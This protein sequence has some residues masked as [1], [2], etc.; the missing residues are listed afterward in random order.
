MTWIWNIQPFSWL[1]VCVRVCACVCVC[2]I[3]NLG[4]SLVAQTVKSLPQY[5][6]PEF[7]CGS[8]R[9]PGEGN[10]NPFQYSCLENPMDGGAWQATAHRVT[11]SQTWLSDFTHSLWWLRWYRICRQCKRPGFEQSLGRENPLD[12]G[13]ATHS[14]ILSW[15]IPW[16]EEPGGLRS[17]GSHRVWHDRATNTLTNTF[18][19]TLNEGNYQTTKDR[20]F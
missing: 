7:D 15:R 13:V 2:V 10:R 11:K 16:T 19:F 17:M 14:S 12:K 5:R 3:W 6:R 20:F 9:S 18:S 4:A 8:G 1:C